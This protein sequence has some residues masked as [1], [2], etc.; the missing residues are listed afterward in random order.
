MFALRN[1]KTGKLMGFTFTTN[2]DGD[3]CTEVEFSLCDYSDSI[4]IVTD[5]AVAD[6][7][8]TTNTDWYNAGFD[9]PGNRYVGELEVVELEI[10]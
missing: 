4:W 9:T 3:F 5:R 1:K 7:A 8:A 6:K 2:S 10:K